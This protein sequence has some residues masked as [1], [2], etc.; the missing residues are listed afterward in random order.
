MI[1]VAKEGL[2]GRTL[3][4]VGERPVVDIFYHLNILT[5]IAIDDRKKFDAS[6]G[7][8]RTV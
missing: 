3:D 2:L 5:D 1:D 8:Y 7:I 6:R 4:E